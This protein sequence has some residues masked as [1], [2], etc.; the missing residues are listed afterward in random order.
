MGAHVYLPILAAIA[1]TAGLV[2]EALPRPAV[3]SVARST[4]HRRNGRRRRLLPEEHVRTRT[5]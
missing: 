4:D 3:L 2:I 5:Y 1:V